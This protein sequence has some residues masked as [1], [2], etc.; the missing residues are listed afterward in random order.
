MRTTRTNRSKLKAKMFRLFIIVFSTITMTY[1]CDSENRDIQTLISSEPLLNMLNPARDRNLIKLHLWNSAAIDDIKFY[2]IPFEWDPRVFSAQMDEV[3]QAFGLNINGIPITGKNYFLFAA[4][5]ASG[6]T[7]QRF[8][9]SSELFQAW[10]GMYTVNDEGGMVYSFPNN[11]FNPTGVI[12]LITADQIA[13][14]VNFAKVPFNFLHVSPA[15]EQPT[16]SSVQI[17]GHDGYSVHFNLTSNIDVGYQNNPNPP[18]Y[19]Y[20]SDPSFFYIPQ[21]LWLN[22]LPFLYQSNTGYNTVTLEC[23]AYV[24]HDKNR[25]NVVYYNGI[26]Y[27][28]SY[29]GGS[30]FADYRTLGN[31]G[32]TLETMAKNVSL[33]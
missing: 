26:I 16:V 13:W 21:S 11:S 28:K 7:S 27:K 20:T 32:S 22:K 31:I 8:D 10:F 17:D 33:Q 4:K 24:W 15:E 12:E 30:L 3:W 14:L 9:P 6:A 5:T 2:Y 23:V 1:G 29:G 25:L 19:P 18:V